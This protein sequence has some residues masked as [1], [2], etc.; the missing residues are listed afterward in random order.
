MDLR[1]GRP[2]VSKVSIEKAISLL[3]E[4]MESTGTGTLHYHKMRDAIEILTPL[5]AANRWVKCED[6]TPPRPDDE[7]SAKYL[8]RFSIGDYADLDILQWWADK[9]WTDQEGTDLDKAVVVTHWM[10]LPE[11]TGE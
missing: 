10:P 3:R 9:S 7:G 2:V 11:Y 5:A 4:G 8:C 6:E 1:G